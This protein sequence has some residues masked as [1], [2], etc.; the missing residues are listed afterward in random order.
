[1]LHIFLPSSIHKFEKQFPL[2]KVKVEVAEQ[3]QVVLVVMVS[4]VKRIL[5]KWGDVLSEVPSGS[6]AGLAGA[7]LSLM[8][9]F[10]HHPT[11]P[12]VG[13]I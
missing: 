7:C 11:I 1:M 4:F 2:V 10:P 9:K 5:D 8:L 13:G 6:S 12:A 3:V